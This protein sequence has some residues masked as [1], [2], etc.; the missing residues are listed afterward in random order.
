MTPQQFVGLGVR[1]FA[2][3]LALEGLG[4]AL[5]TLQVLMSQATHQIPNSLSPWAYYPSLILLATASALWFFPMT[6]AHRVIPRTSFANRL[7]A[8][9][10]D[11]ARISLAMLGLWLLV[12]HLPSVFGFVIRGF[13]VSGE[14][15]VISSMSARDKIYFAT[16]CFQVAMGALLFAKST[17]IASYLFGRPAKP[18]ARQSQEAIAD[19]D[20]LPG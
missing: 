9:A 10:L 6:V 15:S 12:E 2:I 3:W 1:L 14:D 20:Q 5:S 7:D 17:R 11:V 8:S 16:T 18:D 19:K 4:M 13:L